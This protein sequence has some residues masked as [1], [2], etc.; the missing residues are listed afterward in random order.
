MLTL[1][2]PRPKPDETKVNANFRVSATLREKFAIACARQRTD[3]TKQVI[4]FMEDYVATFE[5][6]NGPIN[7][8]DLPSK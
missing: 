1:S 3:A 2:V 5:A 6:L 8:T 7:L 4:G